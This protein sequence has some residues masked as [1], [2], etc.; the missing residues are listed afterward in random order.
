MESAAPANKEAEAG[1]SRNICHNILR[2]QNRFVYPSTSFDVRFYERRTA[3]ARCRDG[4]AAQSKREPLARDGAK[5]VA[6]AAAGYTKGRT[7]GA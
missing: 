7:N 6:A 1:E 3:C 2:K 5:D 4:T